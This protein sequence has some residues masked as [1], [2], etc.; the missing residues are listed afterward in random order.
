VKRYPS[1]YLYIITGLVAFAYVGI[2]TF[3]VAITCDEGWTLFQYVRAPVWDILTNSF[4]AANNHILNTLLT[5]I[6]AQ[7]SESEFS[8][9]LPNLLAFL[10]YIYT[11]YKISGIYFKNTVVRLSFFIAL[12]GNYSILHFFGLCR[13]YGLTIALMLFSTYQLMLLMKQYHKK[14]LHLSLLF[15]VLAMYANFSTMPAV[16]SIII[17]AFAITYMHQREQ[18]SIYRLWEAMKLPL[19]YGVVCMAICAYPIYRLL[20]HDE[21]YYGGENNF[22]SDTFFTL[23]LNYF[24]YWDLYSKRMEMSV[25]LLVVMIITFIITAIKWWDR[26]IRIYTIGTGIFVLSAICINAQF[27]LLGIKL[28]IGRTSMFLYPLIILSIFSLFAFLRRQY[29]IFIMPIPVAIAVICILN[30]SKEANFRS[31]RDWWDDTY[32]R[33]VI[34]YVIARDTSKK[35]ITVAGFFATGNSLNYYAE[36][37]GRTGQFNW[38]DERKTNSPKPDTACDYIFLRREDPAPDSTRFTIVKSWQEDAFLLYHKN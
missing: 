35:N 26:R 34:E 32:T 4:P 9:R 31:V 12:L 20:E 2:R 3:T 30:I 16:L 24:G 19:I 23:L 18:K 17:V 11:S 14:H 7:F 15:A 6:C 37:L 21:L 5:K 28:P 10:L 25:G 33:D 13:G 36:K 22:V 27:Y 38:I 1:L 29:L 8:L